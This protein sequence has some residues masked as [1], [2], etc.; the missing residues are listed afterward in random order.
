MYYDLKTGEHMMLDPYRFQRMAEQGLKR[1]HAIA[2][3]IENRNKR[4]KEESRPVSPPVP[5]GTTVPSAR[6]PN[7]L[8]G[9]PVANNIMSKLMGLTQPNSQVNVFA[10]GKATYPG[11]S[12]NNGKQIGGVSK[13]AIKRRMSKR[14]Y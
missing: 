8:M 11:G 7:T 9:E 4:R 12:P 1:Q 5:T 3:L 13:A 2:V 6:L 10:R 14:M